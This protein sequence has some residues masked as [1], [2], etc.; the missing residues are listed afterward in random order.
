[1]NSDGL[2]L[3]IQANSAKL[4]LTPIHV[5]SVKLSLPST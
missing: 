2:S 4:S 5:N 1:M 3:P